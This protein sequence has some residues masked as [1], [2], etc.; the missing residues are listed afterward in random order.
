[1]NADELRE[2]RQ[3]SVQRSKTHPCCK[4]SGTGMR[5]LNSYFFVILS[6]PWGIHLARAAVREALS[7]DTRAAGR[8][9]QGSPTRQT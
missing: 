4:M 5:Q 2:S 8:A 7:A 9:S 1:M 6:Q 3:T